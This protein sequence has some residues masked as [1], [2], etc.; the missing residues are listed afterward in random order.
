MNLIFFGSFQHYSAMILQSLITDH[1]FMITGVVTT[2]PALVGRKQILTKTP[3][4]ILAEQHHIPVF[5]PEKLEASM[6]SNDARSRTP[7]AGVEDVDLRIEDSM[8]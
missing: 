7:L 1:R 2:P 4:H 6:L 8:I 3:V 5:T